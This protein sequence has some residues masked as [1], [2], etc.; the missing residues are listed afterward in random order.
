VIQQS[1]TGVLDLDGVK[2]DGSAAGVSNV[3]VQA[4]TDVAG[5]RIAPTNDFGAGNT[6]SYPSG[7]LG[8]YGVLSIAAGGTGATSAAAALAMLGGAPLANPSF[9]GFATLTDKSAGGAGLELIGDGATT[10]SKTLRVTLG[11]LQ[12]VNS[13]YSAVI[14]QWDDVGDYQAFGTLTATGK[15]IANG[16][17]ATERGFA[18][19]TGGST[20]WEMATSAGD[21]G[22]PGSNIGSNVGLYAY[23]DAGSYLGMA[24]S[25][26]RNTQV[27]TFTS[28]PVVPTA[29][30]GTNTTQVATTAFVAAAIGSLS[31]GN[32][33]T[34][35]TGGASYLMATTDCF[36]VVKKTIGSSTTITL[37]LLPSNW[38]SYVVKD[39][40]GD[41]SINQITVRG[42][43]IDGQQSF[44][45]AVNYGTATFIF[46][47]TEW[48]VI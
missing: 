20:R 1:G 46:D 35:I 28:M 39:G 27:V 25:V 24:F 6:C 38:T 5:N 23:S 41:A 40:K 47:G 7:S 21:G 13:A 44:V 37:P 42:S 18:I 30:L 36:V 8:S 3:V 19:Q 9:T 45:I 2:F 29:A 11:N 12:I 15:S 22:E 31:Q 43:T 33:G 17:A 10:P 14:G 26:A 32:S 48:S 4:A 16:G 34:I